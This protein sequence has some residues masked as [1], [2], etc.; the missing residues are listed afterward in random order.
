MIDKIVN[1]YER[2]AGLLIRNQFFQILR[3][4]FYINISIY[5]Y[6][7]MCVGTNLRFPI[8]QTKFIMNFLGSHIWRTIDYFLIS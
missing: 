4:R 5:T 2:N 6:Y 3:T 1:N 7:N 8:V